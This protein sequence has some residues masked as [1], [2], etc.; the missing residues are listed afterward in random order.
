MIRYPS[1][2]KLRIQYPGFFCFFVYTFWVPSLFFCMH[3]CLMDINFD[4]TPFL[5]P[6]YFHWM[7]VK[8]FRFG[9]K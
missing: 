1:N 7:R 2:S 9:I 4:W 5:H 8:W 3:D 6:S